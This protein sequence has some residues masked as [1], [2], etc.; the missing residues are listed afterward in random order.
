MFCSELAAFA[1]SGVPNHWGDIMDL[2]A[3]ASL[4]PT[5]CH[6]VA[7]DGWSSGDRAPAP[8]P[9]D[10][11]AFVAAMRDVAATVTIVTTDGPAG[12]HGATVSAFCSV[13]ADPPTVLVCLN[14]TNQISARVRANGR[15][16]VNILRAS[17][18]AADLART[19]AGARDHEQPDRFCHAPVSGR[20][21]EGPSLA[22]ATVLFCRLVAVQ[23]QATH[24][25]CFGQV[26]RIAPG[27][28]GA[29]PL[30][31][32]NRDFASLAPLPTGG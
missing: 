12:R 17:P 5:A 6:H 19:F 25:V 22:G 18:Q 23:V 1:R 24:A 27:T 26:L 2:K 7:N 4:H 16:A 10:R 29:A 20:A 14:S 13:S 9:V 11:A 31:Y 8:A 30:I 32:H 28:E 21:D 15:F 3:D